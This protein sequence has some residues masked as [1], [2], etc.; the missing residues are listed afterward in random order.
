MAFI[1]G[2]KAADATEDEL[3]CQ[4][5]TILDLIMGHV[6]TISYRLQ[7]GQTHKIVKKRYKTFVVRDSNPGQLLGRQLC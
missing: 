5:Q 6:N 1:S 3:L 2:E 4:H 7:N